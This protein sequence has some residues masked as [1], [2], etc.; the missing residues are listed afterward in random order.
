MDTLGY[1][2]ASQEIT[3]RAGSPLEAICSWEIDVSPLLAV[4]LNRE[5][6]THVLLVSGCF[7]LDVDVW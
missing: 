5:S 2:C 3:V 6:S 1:L 4:L 7:G